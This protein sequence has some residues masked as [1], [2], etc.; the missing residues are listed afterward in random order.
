MLL[1][2]ILLKTLLLSQNK[3]HLS[4]GRPQVVGF[5]FDLITAKI[6]V[7]GRFENNELTALETLLFP[8]LPRDGLCLDIG[9]NIGNHAVAFADH[10][11]KVH[12]FEPNPNVFKV[13]RINADLKANIVAHMIGC[14]SSEAEIEVIERRGNIG[15]TGI[16][17]DGGESSGQRVVF[18]VAPLDAMGLFEDDDKTTFVKIDIEGHEADAIR[19]AAS[20]LRRHK[21]VIAM[22]IGRAS[23]SNGSNTA[24]DSLKKLGYSHFYEIPRSHSLRRLQRLGAIEVLPVDRL[25]KRNYPL[26]LAA[27]NPLPFG[28]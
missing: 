25:K 4:A 2:R 17:F 7:D 5:A 24:L 1:R 20:T 6:H 23:I 9:A 26:L 22:E 14:S 3:R 10:F 15:S 27:T 13:L 18:S 28:L 11:A 8:K 16:G 12:A 19:G 21:P